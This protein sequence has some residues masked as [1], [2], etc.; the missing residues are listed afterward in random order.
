[1]SNYANTRETREPPYLADISQAAVFNFYCK[2]YESL[3]NRERIDPRNRMSEGTY[4]ALELK[5]TRSATASMEGSPV[6]I[7]NLRFDDDI[8]TVIP[9]IRTP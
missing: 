3:K 5:R 7:D 8:N 4:I 1:M 6:Q 2:M 9:A